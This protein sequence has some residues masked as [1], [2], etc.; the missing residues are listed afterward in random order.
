MD[1][2][3]AC[4]AVIFGVLAGAFVVG[5]IGRWVY[6]IVTTVRARYVGGAERKT[7]PLIWALPVALL[8]HSTPWLLAVAGYLSYYALSRPHAWWWHWFFGALVASPLLMLV[9]VLR[10]RLLKK[11]GNIGHAA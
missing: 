3:V 8:L 9:P 10:A 6:S 7:R 4:Q 5:A 11:R 1:F 2:L